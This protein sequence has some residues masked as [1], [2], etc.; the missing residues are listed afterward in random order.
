MCEF[1]KRN[2]WNQDNFLGV[3]YRGELESVRFMIDSGAD[4]NA[5]DELGETPLHYAVRGPG[6][7][8]VEHLVESG[9]ILDHR[10]TES[11]DSLVSVAVQLC[12]YP[13]VDLLLRLGSDPFLRG[14]MGLNAIDEAENYKSEEGKKIYE[15]LLQETKSA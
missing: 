11:V 5:F 13:L 3:C 12:N 4:V 15:R 8:V 7:D 9:A 10:G 2:G 1:W 6:L 14:F